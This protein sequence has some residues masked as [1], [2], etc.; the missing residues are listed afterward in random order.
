MSCLQRSALFFLISLLALRNFTFSQTSSTSLRGSVTDP[1]GKGILGATVALKNM[2]SGMERSLATDAEGSY[3][4]QQLPAGSYILTVLA[5]SFAKYERK[6]LV[7]LVNTPVTA[8][9]QLKIG[10]SSETVTV[11]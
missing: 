8:N 5:P 4:F 10:T 1:S 3:Q 9:V 6:D 7:L 2:E 11:T